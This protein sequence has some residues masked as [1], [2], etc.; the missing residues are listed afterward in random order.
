LTYLLLKLSQTFYSTFQSPTWVTLLLFI[1]SG[2]VIFAVSLAWN[3]FNNYR[4]ARAIGA[5]LPPRISDY[6]PG[7]I[8]SIWKEIKHEETGYFGDS[9]FFILATECSQVLFL[10]QVMG[11]TPK[12]RI[13][14]D[15]HSI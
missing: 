7:N 2:P 15:F 3:D 13:P 10:F 11:L 4:A 8:Y 14:E 1:L 9:P 6:S 5:V 12:Q